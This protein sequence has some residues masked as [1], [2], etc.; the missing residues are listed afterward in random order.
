MARNDEAGTRT[1]L[2][3]L[4][5]SPLQSDRDKATLGLAQLALKRADCST[6]RQLA[7]PLATPSGERSESTRKRARRIVDVCTKDR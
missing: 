6:A 4:A 5:Q 1:A 7:L 3:N 2:G